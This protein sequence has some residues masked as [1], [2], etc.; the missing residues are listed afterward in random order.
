MGIGGEVDVVQ[1][2]Q[3]M[4]V[5]RSGLEGVDGDEAIAAGL[6]FNGDRLTPSFRKFVGQQTQH[7]FWPAAHREGRGDAHGLGGKLLGLGNS[8]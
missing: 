4:A 2:D 8:A 1:L 5:G 6:V 3:F 7:A